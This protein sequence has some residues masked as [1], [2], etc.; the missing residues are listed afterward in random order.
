MGSESWISTKIRKQNR[1]SEEVDGGQK[2]RI[3]NS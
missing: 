2:K 3:E 1:N